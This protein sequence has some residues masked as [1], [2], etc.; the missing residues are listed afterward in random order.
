MKINKENMYIKT[1]ELGLEEFGCFFESDFMECLREYIDSIGKKDDEE[2]SQHCI[3]GKMDDN[4][5]LNSFIDYIYSN[6]NDKAAKDFFDAYSRK[7]SK[8][9][10]DYVE[11]FIACDLTLFMINGVKKMFLTELG[12][13]YKFIPE[14]SNEYNKLSSKHDFYEKKESKRLEELK[15]KYVGDKDEFYDFVDDDEEYMNSCVNKLLIEDRQDSLRSELSELRRDM[16]D[17]LYFDDSAH[18]SNPVLEVIDEFAQ[19][20]SKQLLQSRKKSYKFN[21]LDYKQLISMI[22]KV[23]KLT[24]GTVMIVISDIERIAKKNGIILDGT[25]FDMLDYSFSSSVFD[26]Y[27]YDYDIHENESDIANDIVKRYM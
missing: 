27:G 8:Y 10:D 14:V 18:E 19:G 25:D 20:K 15:E 17:Y 24:P 22:K 16:S 11:P 7:F 3:S 21:A 9:N 26:D 23:G 12:D 5:R 1:D 4:I 13:Y 2:I 6:L